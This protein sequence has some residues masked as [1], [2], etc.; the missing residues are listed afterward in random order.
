[1]RIGTMGGRPSLGGNTPDWVMDAVGANT[2]SYYDSGH[3]LKTIPLFWN[4]TFLDKKKAMIAAVARAIPAIRWSRWQLQALPTAIVKI[5]A[6]WTQRELTEFRL[7][8]RRKRV[9]CSRRATHTQKWWT[10]ECK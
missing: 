7:L 5:G 6:C 10:L 9:E 3:T 1:I 8:A 4:Q 2:I